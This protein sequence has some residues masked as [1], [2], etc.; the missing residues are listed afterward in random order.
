M[1]KHELRMIKDYLDLKYPSDTHNLN[2]D[3]VFDYYSGLCSQILSGRKKIGVKIYP[4]N[5]TEEMTIINYIEKNKDNLYGKEMENFYYLLNI[6][7]NIIG[8]YYD[9]DGNLKEI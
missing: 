8:I 2:L 6:V 7:I 5:E 3:S 1:K 9:I 4:L